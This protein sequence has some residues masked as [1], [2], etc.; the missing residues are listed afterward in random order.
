MIVTRAVPLAILELSVGAV[1]RIQCTVLAGNVIRI[2]DGS[3]SIFFLL[4]RASAKRPVNGGW[5]SWSGW[6]GCS[7][8]CRWS[9]SRDCDNPTPM[10]GGAVCSG[11]GSQVSFFENC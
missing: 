7:A 3:G 9:K 4:H 1:A 10:F 2:Q 5:S 11:S 6:A 8:D